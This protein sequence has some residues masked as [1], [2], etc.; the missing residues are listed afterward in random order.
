[1]QI[2]W[3]YLKQRKHHSKKNMKELNGGIIW[4][5]LSFGGG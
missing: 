4:K 2:L 5:N 3:H 1:M